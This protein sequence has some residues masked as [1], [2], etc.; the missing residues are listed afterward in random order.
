MFIELQGAAAFF[1]S[2]DIYEPTKDVYELRGQAGKMKTQLSLI[3]FYFQ[4]SQRN[5]SKKNNK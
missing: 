3:T 1:V 4:K 5:I 2:F